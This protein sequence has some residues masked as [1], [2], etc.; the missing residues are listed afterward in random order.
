MIYILTILMISR[1]WTLPILLD[2][3]N[4][5]ISFCSCCNNGT[6][7]FLFF[8]NFKLIFSFVIFCRH[9][10]LMIWY[11]SCLRAINVSFF[12]RSMTKNF[13]FVLCLLTTILV[14]H[15]LP[16][17]LKWNTYNIFDKWII[18]VTNDD[19]KKRKI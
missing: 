1:Y 5:I 15:F 14:L 3:S 17:Y 9:Y 10:I 18:W 19:C 13:E 11:Q 8:F 6:I 7:F 16:E 4:E 12:F 2:I